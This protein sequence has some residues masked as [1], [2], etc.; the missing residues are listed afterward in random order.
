MKRSQP[1]LHALAETC[2]WPRFFMRLGTVWTQHMSTGENVST[3]AMQLIF[4]LEKPETEKQ[5]HHVYDDDDSLTRLCSGRKHTK[6]T[7][8]AM[9]CRHFTQQYGL[10]APTSW[11]IALDCHISYTASAIGEAGSV[12]YQFNSI[13]LHTLEI[14]HS[15]AYPEGGLKVL[16]II[17]GTSPPVQ[18]KGVKLQSKKSKANERAYNITKE[19]YI[20]I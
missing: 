16:I 10:S 8:T 3:H 1:N 17:G 4:T 9:H 12:L 7:C 14:I 6:L 19:K 11:N 13:L 15:F 2:T 18:V 5:M 20:Y